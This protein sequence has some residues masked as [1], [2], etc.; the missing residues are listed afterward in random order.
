MVRLLHSLCCLG[1]VGRDRV[2][3]AAVEKR[4]ETIAEEKLLL[5]KKL[6]SKDEERVGLEREMAG[7]KAQLRTQQVEHEAVVV[8]P[9]PSAASCRSVCLMLTLRLQRHTVEHAG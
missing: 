5:E 8:R 4:S 9:P 6:E 1:E 3:L 7:A 2:C